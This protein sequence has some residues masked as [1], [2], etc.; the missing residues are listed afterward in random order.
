MQNVIRTIEGRI[1]EIIREDKTITLP[2]GFDFA[3]L[4]E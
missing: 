1:S 2:K 3:W 4:E